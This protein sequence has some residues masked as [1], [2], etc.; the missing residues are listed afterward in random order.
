MIKAN[1]ALVETRAIK[2][3]IEFGLINTEAINIFEILKY[4]PNVSIIRN[5]I[6]S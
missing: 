5:S 1:N 6:D 4:N 3:R 2:T